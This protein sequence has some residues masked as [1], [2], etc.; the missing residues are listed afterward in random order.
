M[1]QPLLIV[2][3]EEIILFG[4]CEYFTMHG[5]EV[6]CAQELDEAK[7]LLAQA[8]YALVIC[9]EKS[10]GSGNEKSC[11]RNLRQYPPKSG[12]EL[13]TKGNPPGALPPRQQHQSS[14]Y[15]EPIG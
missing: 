4:M 10:I 14:L 13:R 1:S 3:D 6:E 15:S 8:R 7:A 12:V 2:D 5:Y 9:V 11:D